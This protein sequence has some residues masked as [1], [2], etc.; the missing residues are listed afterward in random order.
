MR[1]VLRTKKRMQ[2]IFFFS[3]FFWLLTPSPRWLCFW[4][5]LFVNFVCCSFVRLF[6]CLRNYENVA[7][8]GKRSDS[9]RNLVVE[10]LGKEETWFDSDCLFCPF[11]KSLWSSSWTLLFYSLCIWS[12]KPWKRNLIIGPWVFSIRITI[13]TVVKINFSYHPFVAF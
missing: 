11:V 8:R 4:F 13:C 5:N 3:C 12:A 2:V 1:Y 10:S 7:I 9:E 6:S